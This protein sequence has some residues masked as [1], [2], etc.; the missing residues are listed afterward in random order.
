MVSGGGPLAVYVRGSGGAGEGAL[1]RAYLDEMDRR[2]GATILRGRCYERERVPYQALDGVIDALARHLRRMRMDEASALL[3]EGIADLASIF[4]VLQG[5]AA[6]ADGPHSFAPSIDPVESERRA[7]GALESLLRR[8]SERRP[9]VLSIED[10]HWGD[11]ESAAWIARLFEG[12]P[13]SILLVGTYRAE[14]AEAS[15]MLRAMR[16]LGAEGLMGARAREIALGK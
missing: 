15:L 1:V 12:A 6:V 13:S 16:E 3:S 14:E 5:V 8:L 10:L 2:G 4:P 11:R 9:L 7:L